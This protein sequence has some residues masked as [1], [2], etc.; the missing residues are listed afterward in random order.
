M[1]DFIL[2]L[3]LVMDSSYLRLL[4]GVREHDRANVLYQAPARGNLVVLESTS[5]SYSTEEQ[6][7]FL[8]GWEKEVAVG[9]VKKVFKST[10]SSERERVQKLLSS[11]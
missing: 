3:H 9:N 5:A 2:F 7:A 6:D 11:M 10:P 4:G 1:S 8:C